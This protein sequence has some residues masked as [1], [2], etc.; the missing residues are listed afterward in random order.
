MDSD[1]VYV[2]KN[3][4]RMESGTHLALYEKRGT[5]R[6]IFHASARNLNI[7]KLA[8]TMA[9]DGDEVLDTALYFGSSCHAPYVGI[10]QKR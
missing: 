1:C 6:E 10:S 4:E 8:E 5:Y 9:D 3:G 2:M 7:E